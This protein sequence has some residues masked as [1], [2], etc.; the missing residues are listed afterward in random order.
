MTTCVSLQAS[1][2]LVT[3]MALVSVVNCTSATT[4]YCADCSTRTTAHQRANRSSARGA[5][6][7]AKNGITARMP[8]AS[9]RAVVTTIDNLSGFR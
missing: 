5:A 8:A 1:N 7:Y 4:G 6:A 2:S 9:M 3:V